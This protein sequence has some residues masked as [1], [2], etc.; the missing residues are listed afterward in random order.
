ME[1]IELPLETERFVIRPLRE[2]DA[3]AMH[4]VW[5]DP[6]TMLFPPSAP[7]ASLDE[8]RGR[9]RRHI[10]RQREFGLS[11]WAVEERESG[12]VV[13]VCGLF[14]VGGTGPDVEVAYHI[15]RR[16]W[17]RGV[18]T[19]SARACVEAGLAAG[20]PEILAFAFPENAASLRVMEKIGM[21]PYGRVRLYGTELVRYGTA[22]SATVV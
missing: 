17:N 11:L 16:H 14:P 1:P 10:E 6:E 3:E 22:P 9:V 7:S 8:T 20:L 15:S 13:G 12:D 18:A 19:E 4:E 21:R 5:S 2:D